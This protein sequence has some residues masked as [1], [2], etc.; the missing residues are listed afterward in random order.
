MVQ[1]QNNNALTGAVVTWSS[2]NTSVASVSTQGLVTALSNGTS[3]ITARSGSVSANVG[4]TVM[5]TLPNRPPEPVGQIEPLVLVEGGPTVEVDISGAFRDPDGDELKFAVESS[6]DQVATATVSGV[7]VTIVPVS[8]GSADITVTATDPDGL[9]ATQTIAVTVEEQENKPPEA[10]GQIEP[11]VLVEGGPPVEVDVSGAFRDPDG[12]ELKFAV[13]SNDDQVATATV[14]GVMVTIVPV[15]A[16]SA[17]ITVTATDP[18]GLSATQTI[19]VTVEEQENKPPEAVGQIEPLVLVEGGPTVEVD[20]SG[21][22]NDPDGDELKFAVESS[23]DQ[24]ATAT[25]SGVMVTI[26]PVSAGSADI[27][28]TA[29]DP[30]GL[31]AAQTFEVTVEE[32]ENRPPDPVGVIEPL[33]LVEGDPPVEVDVSGAFRDPD[34][35]E[36]KFAVESSDDRVATASV[37]GTKVTVV[38]VSAG[39]ADITVTATDPDG[40]SATQTIA[41]TVEE[42]ENKP[43]EP[44]SVIAPLMLV[45]GGPTVEVDVSGAFRDPDGDE[46][47]F[48]VE[49]SDDM[50]ATATVSGVLVAIAPVSAGSADITVTATD[51]DGLSATQTIAVTVEEQ[52]NKPPEPVSVIAPLMLVE[53][54]PTVEVDVSGA[55]RDPDGDE[56]KF[57]VE[58]SDDLV[59]TATLSGVMV[60]IVPVSAGSATITATATDADGLS[61]AQTFEVTVE[62]KENKPPEAVG[63]IAP[64]M[65]VEGGP[66]VE[67]DVSG[68]FSDPDGDELEYT[69]FS[70][71]DLV[72]TVEMNETRIAI[73]PV[74]PGRATV[75]VRATDPDG[76]SATQNFIVTTAVSSPNRNTL[77]ELYNRMGGQD[78]L[79][80]TNWLTNAPLNQW[81]GV[82]T[83]ADGQVTRLA[84][85]NNNLHGPLPDELLQLID[86]TVLNLADNHLTGSIPTDLGQLASLEALILKG[87]QLSGIIPSDIDHLRNLEVFNLAGNQLSG[88]IPA[89]IEH[90]STLE[91]L[92]LSENLLSGPIPPEIGQLNELIFLELSVNQL[93]GVLPSE[94]G[95]LELLTTLNV[96]SNAELSGPLPLSL[97][98]LRL[99]SFRVNGTQLCVPLN[100]EFQEWLSTISDLSDIEGCP[101]Q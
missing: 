8:A 98:S 15:S 13:E 58:S 28:V 57:A 94:I 66:T 23:D 45:E 96:A 30:D 92:N 90:L 49:S 64:L 79:D 22:F 12:D 48:A 74:S 19:A 89:E 61:A 4:V 43:P 93:T 24:V 76:L 14:S 17:D 25:V 81:H 78:W 86:L 39:S 85:I 95:R 42:Q 21:A 50:V 38:P 33:M 32:P 11:L 91:S 83:D 71:D 53:G 68:A 26:V 16:G 5:A 70:T 18:D 77:I 55:F 63:V 31:S 84:L 35:D 27:T 44:V 99:E 97:S 41:V 20:I 37:S 10:V 67:V 65:L 80:R 36:L 88:D 54:G 51:P 34:D 9:S 62:E 60:T 40:L 72:T 29:A 87:N 73:A 59:A 3:L 46:L 82:T 1:D 2:S 6:D 7:M 69:A 52:E 56:L 100:E 75:T 47:K 101:D